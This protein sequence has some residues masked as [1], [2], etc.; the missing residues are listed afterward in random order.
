MSTLQ[1]ICTGSQWSTANT[2]FIISWTRHV[3]ITR[4]EFSTDWLTDWLTPSLWSI[5]Q[6]SDYVTL[7]TG[8]GGSLRSITIRRTLS[9]KYHNKMHKQPRAQLCK[10]GLVLE[11]TATPSICGWV[12]CS[13]QG[14]VRVNRVTYC[15]SSSLVRVLIPHASLELEPVA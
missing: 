1:P 11:P 8:G 15:A 6:S 13:L 5:I 7:S 3:L 14:L 9:V 4:W 12:E 2:K 10:G